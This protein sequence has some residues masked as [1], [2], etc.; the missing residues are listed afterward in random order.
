MTASI[1]AYEHGEKWLDELREY[2]YLN[3]KSVRGFIEK[4][5]PDINIVNS[6]A[7]YLLWLDC[8][9]I[10]ENTDALADDIRAKTGLYLSK[11]SAF[12]KGGEAFLRMNTACPKRTLD[13]GLNRLKTYFK[14]I[15]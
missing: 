14:L 4:E 7:T 3:K 11:G 13:D 6:H 8:S 10:C 12:G 5:I 2:L 15:K 1:A 9:K